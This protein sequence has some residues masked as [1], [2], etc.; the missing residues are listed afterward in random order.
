METWLKS[1]YKDG[2]WG[3][4]FWK[5]YDALFALYR[6]GEDISPYLREAFSK[7]EKHYR[8]GSYDEVYDYK[9]AFY[10]SDFSVLVIL[11]VNYITKITKK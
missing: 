6:M 8:N 10:R 1:E 3:N 9:Y 11:Y 7:I 4:S 5:T 2:L